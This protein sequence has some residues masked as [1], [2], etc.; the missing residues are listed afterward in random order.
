MTMGA[1]LG[2]ELG[3]D[4]PP[5]LPRKEH[6]DRGVSLLESLVQMDGYDWHEVEDVHIRDSQR[7]RRLRQA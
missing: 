3:K 7:E 1:E 4:Q 2:S 5:T 6:S